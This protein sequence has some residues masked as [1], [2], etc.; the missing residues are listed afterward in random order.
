MPTMATSVI[1]HRVGAVVGRERERDDV[2]VAGGERLDDQPHRLADA[3][4]RQVVGDDARFDEHL[5]AEIHVADGV[6]TEVGALHRVRRLRGEQLHR[7]RPERALASATRAPRHP[8]PAQRGHDAWRGKRDGRAVLHSRTGECER[9]R[10]VGEE[11]RRR[12]SGGPL[13]TSP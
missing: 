2:A 4:R 1:A 6:R 5:T 7:E 8:T 13:T 10:V 11:R 3:Q 9:R 12:T